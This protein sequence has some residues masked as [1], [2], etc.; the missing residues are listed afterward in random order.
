MRLKKIMSKD[1]TL[2]SHVDNGGNSSIHDYVV[3]L[4]CKKERDGI[5]AIFD[6]FAEL[7]SRGFNKATCHESDKKAGIF[8]IRKRDHRFLFFHGNDRKVIVF[9]CPHVKKGQ[10]VSKTEVARIK[11]IKVRYMNAHSTGRLTIDD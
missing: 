9:A 4:D 5:A 8:Q 10:K 1:W 7:G 6:R 3:N 2:L 11:A